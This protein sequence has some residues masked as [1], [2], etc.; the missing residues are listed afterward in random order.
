MSKLDAKKERD[1]YYVW[2]DKSGRF[3]LNESYVF[4]DFEYVFQIPIDNNGDEDFIQG[5]MMQSKYKGQVI[6]VATSFELEINADFY[7]N[8]GT[9]LMQ[10]AV[11]MQEKNNSD[12]DLLHEYFHIYN[13]GIT[14]AIKNNCSGLLVMVQLYC[15]SSQIMFLLMD[16]EAIS[17]LGSKMVTVAA[18][19]K[20][21]QES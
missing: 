20:N 21:A 2:T 15:V 12:E 17:D 5:F 18:Q 9:L 1:E 16:A 13:G 4:G 10:A 11:K 14:F 19:I 8:M 3:I 7:H 6:S